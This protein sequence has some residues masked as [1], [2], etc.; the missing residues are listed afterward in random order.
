MY[1]P[2]R[3]FM[4][5][6][7]KIKWRNSLTWSMV[8]HG[9]FFLAGCQCSASERWT[10]PKIFSED[11]IGSREL[12]SSMNMFVVYS[13]LLNFVIIDFGS[14]KLSLFCITLIALWSLLHLLRW[15]IALCFLLLKAFSFW[16]SCMVLHALLVI[17]IIIHR[18]QKFLLEGGKDTIIS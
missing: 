6:T 5:V 17:I 2:Y 9:F 16:Q 14:Y 13:S 12:P 3:Q 7:Y 4:K 10:S 1:R 18:H 15:D 11:A 8:K